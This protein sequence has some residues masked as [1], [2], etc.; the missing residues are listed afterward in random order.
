MA[1]LADKDGGVEGAAV[2]EDQGPGVGGQLGPRVRGQGVGARQQGLGGG[3][4][5]HLHRGA[6]G[7]GEGWGG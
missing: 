3:V 2:E 7:E 6:A 4:T 5:M 1:V